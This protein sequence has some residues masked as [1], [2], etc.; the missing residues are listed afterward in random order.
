MISVE[1]VVDANYWYGILAFSPGLQII[2]LIVD[3]NWHYFTCII[4]TRT[5]RTSTTN[6][7][8]FFENIQP[9]IFAT[10]MEAHGIR[11]VEIDGVSVSNT[12][13]KYS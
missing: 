8:S 3:I 6:E 10:K 13:R 7:L 11:I 2:Y 9:C 12:R 1:T 5:I 4:R